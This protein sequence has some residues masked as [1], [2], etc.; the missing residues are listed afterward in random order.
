M[1]IHFMFQ[2]KRMKKKIWNQWRTK[3]TSQT[4]PKSIQEI[5]AIAK[6]I[7]LK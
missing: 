4:N 7:Q 2:A 5:A 3:T 1:C 6:N